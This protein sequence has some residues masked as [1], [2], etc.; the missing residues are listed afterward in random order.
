MSDTRQWGLGPFAKHPANPILAPGA[1]PWESHA[2]Y[3]PAAWSDGER[4]FLLYRA[5]G[6]TDIPGR[7]FTSRI[8]LATSADG[9]AFTRHGR[10]VLE[11]SEPYEL[12]GGCE[13]PR[14]VRIG[15]RFVLTYTAYD[16]RVARLALAESHDLLRWERRG[17]AFDDAQWDGYFPAGRFPDTPRGWSKSGAI[18]PEPI[19][20]R[21]WMYFGDTCIW[22]AHSA[23]LRRWEIVPEPVLAPR[24]GRFDAR[25]VEP[26]PPPLLRDDGI[27]LI[28]NSAD[29]RLRYA[30]GQALLDPLDPA[31]VLR[32]SDAPLLEPTEAAEID[33]QVPQVVFAEG[34]VRHSGGWLLYYGMAD[35]RLGV[36]FA[37]V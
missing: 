14:V 18:L 8:C 15:G 11:P 13:D 16:G 10:P 21:H 24:P 19:G 22:A 4:V 31:R 34:L 26:G 3:N 25:L 17:L 28:Y 23:D 5:E 1:A 36:A 27:L 6:A 30:V 32:R 37:P 29:E 9:L 35:S 7:A 33:G 12:P 20:G 2:L